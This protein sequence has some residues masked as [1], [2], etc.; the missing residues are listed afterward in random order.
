MRPLRDFTAELLSLRGAAVE[1]AGDGLE[2]VLPLQLASPLGLPEYARLAFSTEDSAGPLV[3]LD[4]DVFERLGGLL[5][6][7]GVFCAAYIAAPQ[8]KLGKIEESFS[9]WFALDNAVFR[10]ENVEQRT[11]PYLVAC[12]KFTATSNE[13]MDGMLAVMVNELTLSARLLGSDCLNMLAG[14]SELVT[15]SAERR[16]SSEVL[17]ALDR[18]QRRFIHEQ[19]QDFTRSL[20]RRLNRDAARVREYYGTLVSETRRFIERKAHSEEDRE[21]GRRKIEAVETELKW[22]IQDLVSS[23]RMQIRVEP[24]SFVRIEAF[25][26]LFHIEIKRRK[27]TRSLTIAYN[28]ILRSLDAPPCE[29]CFKCGRL[30]SVCDEKLH[31]LCPDCFKACP[32][33]GKQFCRACHKRGCPRCGKKAG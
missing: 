13:R 18:T 11:I 28:P 21:K 1:A 22:K 6:G 19:I 16:D 8:V 3:S 24:V 7:R 29:E 31:L 27:G 30:Y 15:G 9:E 4:S 32:E 33:C 20:E 2:A 25:V 17:D 10:V 5:E 26:P 12:L 14:A 23:Y